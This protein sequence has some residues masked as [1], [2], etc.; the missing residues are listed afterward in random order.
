MSRRRANHRR[1]AQSVTDT[2]P[3]TGDLHENADGH[4]PLRLIFYTK[5]S[6]PLCER[7]SLLVEP[8]LRGLARQRGVAWI[9]RDIADDPTWQAAYGQRVP[10]LA[11]PT[12]SG[13]ES[14]ILEGRPQADDVAASMAQLAGADR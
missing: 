10:V 2:G 8:H 12:A 3:V 13:E 5:A 14:V 7:L 9:E 6:C 11:C 1:A 4:S